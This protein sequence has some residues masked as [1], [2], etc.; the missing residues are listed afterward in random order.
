LEADHYSLDATSLHVEVDGQQRTIALRT[1]DMK[2]TL[3]VNHQ[4]GVDLNIPKSHSEIF[5]AF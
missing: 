3:A 2:T 1:L 5:L 4:R